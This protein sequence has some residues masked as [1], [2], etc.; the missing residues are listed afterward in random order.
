MRIPKLS[1]L[2]FCEGCV[3]GKMKR[4][5]F[6]PVGEIR[7]TRLLER[8]HS[9]VCGPLSVESIGRKK[10]FVTLMHDYS[11]CCRVYFM[12][13]KNEVFEKFKEFEALV[14]ND[15]GSTIGVLRSDNGGEY[16]TGEFESYLKLKGIHHELT[17]PHTPEQN[18]VAERMNR[19]LMESA[20]SMLAH[21]GLP[22]C[23]WAEAVSTAAYLKNRTATTAF[24]KVATPYERWY[25]RKPN[26][27]NLRVFGCMAYA[28]IPDSQRT[29]LDKKAEKMRFVGYSIQSKGY[30]LLDE[31]TRN[32]L[33]R[34]D[35]VF[36]ETDFGQPHPE[37]RKES[38]VVEM[39]E[40][41]STVVQE[42]QVTPDPR[43]QE[44]HA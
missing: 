24:E 10:Y 30:R 33:V 27:S 34:R 6:Q 23:Y 37:A 12:R 28:H 26:I 2:L 40:R 21:A 7:S 15:I 22:H 16:I 35:V 13:Q 3:E 31:K 43:S 42:Q 9:D 38:L 44:T 19:T 36:N 32:V 11:R 8:V 25:G 17:V 20:R 29:K 1:Q 18:G 5:P 4:K 41:P 39:D 14:T